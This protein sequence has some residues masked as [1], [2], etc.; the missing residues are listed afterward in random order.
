MD[1]RGQTLVVCYW[2]YYHWYI[3]SILYIVNY[4]GGVAIQSQP[5]C[6]ASK[7]KNVTQNSPEMKRSRGV[8]SPGAHEGY[9]TP[10]GREDTDFW[11]FEKITL[12]FLLF[13]FRNNYLSDSS[14][15][16]L[17]FPWYLWFFYIFAIFLILEIFWSKLKIFSLLVWIVFTIYL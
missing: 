8:R 13:S 12:L 11:R 14:S 17:I 1:P 3:F 10:S 5:S 15:L 9:L 6:R 4:F 7:S 16:P 2:E